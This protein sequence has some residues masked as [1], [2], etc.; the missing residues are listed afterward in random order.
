MKSITEFYIN[1][2]RVVIVESSKGQAVVEQ[3]ASIRQVQTRQREPVFIFL[4]KAFPERNVESCVL[5]QI[6]PGILCI[7]QTVGESRSVIDIRGGE[8]LPGKPAI[9][10]QVQRVPL[11]V[12][13]R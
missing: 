4:A 12:I 2:P 7:W 5:R 9:D 6:V 1:L 13:H 3:H 8:H 10:A 11:I